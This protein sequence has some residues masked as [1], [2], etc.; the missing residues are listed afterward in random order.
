MKLMKDLIL[1]LLAPSKEPKIFCMF[2]NMQKDNRL[3]INS[4]CE[5]D[6]LEE[7]QPWRSGQFRFPHL[8][9]K[10]VKYNPD[11]KKGLSYARFVLV[12]HQGKKLKIDLKDGTIIRPLRNIKFTEGHHTIKGF[13]I[14]NHHTTAVNTPLLNRRIEI[15]IPHVGIIK[16]T[17]QNRGVTIDLYPEAQKNLT[18]ASGRGAL[19]SQLCAKEIPKLSTTLPLQKGQDEIDYANSILHDK[20]LKYFNEFEK[21]KEGNPQAN[22]PDKW[23]QMGDGKGGKRKIPPQEAPKVDW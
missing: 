11:V 21:W 15:T 8:L 3:V 17:T 9:K 18:Q 1:L 13:S 10:L 4:Y 12:N 2:D 5:Y 14:F 23:T 22:T 16:L 7:W 6:A 19:I 20:W